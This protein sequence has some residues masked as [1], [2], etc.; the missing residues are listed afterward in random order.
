MSLPEKKIGKRT[1]ALLSGSGGSLGGLGLGKSSGGSVGSSNSKALSGGLV[2]S[3]NSKALS[4]GRSETSA[5]NLLVDAE[6]GNMSALWTIVVIALLVS[7]GSAS[8]S[9]EGSR[10]G[11]SIG[12]FLRSAKGR[13]RARAQ[14][15]VFRCEL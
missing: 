8:A 5:R 4:G 13:G 1:A 2:G 3:S 15:E 9:A 11:I 7:A 6:M 12:G 14:S 10:G